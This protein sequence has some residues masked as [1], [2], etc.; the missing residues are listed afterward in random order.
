VLWCLEAGHETVFFGQRCDYPGLPFI[1]A[2][3]KEEAMA[4]PFF[5]ECSLVILHFGI[6]YQLFDI[7]KTPLIPIKYLVFFHN[8]TPK[9]FVRTESWDTIEKSI[10]QV[11]NISQADR[12]VC[13]SDTNRQVL[14]D[15]GVKI[16]SIVL[17]IPVDTPSAAPQSKPAF[18]SDIVRIAFLGRFVISKGPADLLNALD[19]V[20]RCNYGFRVRLDMLGNVEMSDQNILAYVKTEAQKLCATYSGRISIFLHESIDNKTKHCILSDADIFVLPTRHEGF[21]VPIIEAFAAGCRIITYNNSNLPDVCD[22]RG[23]LV[24]TGN[25][26]E[27]ANAIAEEAMRV[28]SSSW[29]SSEYR[30]FIRSTDIYLEKYRS[31][32]IRPIFLQIIQETIFWSTAEKEHS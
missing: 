13:I 31:Y 2:A 25:I 1:P 11:N 24:S 19:L 17:P 14:L 7:L 15:A 21:C 3:T 30:E 29:E 6:Y 10:E 8:I 32:S 16:P 28:R 23:R 20:A 4:D 12:V 18:G 27:L 5:K 22:G 26:A 9:K